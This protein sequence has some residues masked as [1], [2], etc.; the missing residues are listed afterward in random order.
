MRIETCVIG[1]P[2]TAPT[3]DAGDAEGNSVALAE[4]R[5]AVEEELQERAVDISE[6]EEAEIVGVNWQSLRG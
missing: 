5:F 6:A 4:F 2:S 1:N 3:G